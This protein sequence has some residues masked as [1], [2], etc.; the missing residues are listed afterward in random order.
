MST[1]PVWLTGPGGS[2]AIVVTPQTVTAGVLADTT[3]V[4]TLTGNLDRISIS[5]SKTSEN[6]MAM[7]SFRRNQVPLDVGTEITLIEILKKS[8]TNL[9]AT[10]WMGNSDYFKIG[11][12]RGGQTWTFFGLYESYD[13]GLE[14]GKSVGT[15]RFVM[16]DPGAGNPGYA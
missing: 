6:I 13:E 15:G 10:A 5:G 9:L 4:A 2:Y 7:D 11:V 8:G 12:T 1:I 16:V 3:P 14:H